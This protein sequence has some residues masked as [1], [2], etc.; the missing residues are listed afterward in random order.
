MSRKTLPPIYV[1]SRSRV[2]LD[3]PEYYA[4]IRL[5]YRVKFYFF[6]IWKTVNKQFQNNICYPTC[7]PSVDRMVKTIKAEGQK[8]KCLKISRRKLVKEA[9]IAS[10]H[11]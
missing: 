10:N 2:V 1:C 7:S 8:Y 6:S 11:Q 5:Q 4:E 9:L 3:E